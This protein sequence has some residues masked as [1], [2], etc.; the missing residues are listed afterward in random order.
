MWFCP[1][2]QTFH[3]LLNM[4]RYV[5]KPGMVDPVSSGI[6]GEGKVT[7]GIS[8][9]FVIESEEDTEARM[10]ENRMRR[11]ERNVIV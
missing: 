6:Q 9:H 11:F 8:V 1:I 2:E 10:G 3:D 7:Y 4:R 5:P